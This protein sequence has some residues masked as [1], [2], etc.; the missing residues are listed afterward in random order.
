MPAPSQKLSRAIAESLANV[1]AIY[2][3][4]QQLRNRVRIKHDYRKRDPAAKRDRQ[5]LRRIAEL[6]YADSLPS[7]E[8]LPNNIAD[9]IARIYA[10]A[11][12]KPETWRPK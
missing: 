11:R 8:V 2:K 7:G 6:C 10:L 4:N 9:S 1:D 3:E 5:A 12:G